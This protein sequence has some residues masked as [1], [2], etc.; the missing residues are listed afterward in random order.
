MTLSRKEREKIEQNGVPY[1][2]AAIL[3][4]WEDVSLDN[5]TMVTEKWKQFKGIDY[6]LSDNNGY[7]IYIDT[8][9]HRGKM[10]KQSLTSTGVN[11]L[12]IE[13]TKANGKKGWGINKALKT[14]YVVEVI[15]GVY[16]YVLDAHKLHEYMEEHYLDYP[17][18]YSSKGHEDYRGVSV[19]DLIDNKVI[20]FYAPWEDI[21]ETALSFATGSDTSYNDKIVP[22]L[23]GLIT[24][25][26]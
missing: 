3:N 23:D 1:S 20:V 7:E 17:T 24:G 6:I 18:I 12:S 10:Y 25:K 21:E 4:S 14:D 22:L 13:I 15:G 26:Q 2:I 5:L 19:S 9:F 16:Y 11:I 8:K